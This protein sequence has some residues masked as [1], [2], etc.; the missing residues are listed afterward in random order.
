MVVNFP[1]QICA[2]CVAPGCLSRQMCRPMV[3]GLDLCGNQ[4]NSSIP[5]S[6]GDLTSLRYESGKVV[7]DQVMDSGCIVGCACRL[8]QRAVA[9]KCSTP[10]YHPRPFF[11]PVGTH[12]RNVDR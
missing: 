4:F 1:R 7:P 6:V 2:T 9:V 5:D 12:V 8:C 3:R 10:W 11:Y